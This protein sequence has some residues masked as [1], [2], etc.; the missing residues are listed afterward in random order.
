MTDGRTEGQRLMR[1]SLD[2]HRTIKCVSQVWRRCAVR[3]RWRLARST[4][5]RQ[6][7]WSHL[8]RSRRIAQ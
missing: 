4:D 5:C 6:L 3:R 8:S 7:Y 2:C 1:H